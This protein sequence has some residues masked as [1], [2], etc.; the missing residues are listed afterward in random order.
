[1]IENLEY[2]VLLLPGFF[3]YITLIKFLGSDDERN[4][5]ETVFYSLMLSIIV[6][7]ILSILKQFE[8]VSFELFDWRFGFWIIVSYVIITVILL[9]FFKWIFPWIEKKTQL[10]DHVKS[11]TRD[12]LYDILDDKLNP[13]KT[14]ES[15][16]KKTPI[17]IQILTKDNTSYTGNLVFQGLT[18]DKKEAVYIKQPKI[19]NKDN[20]MNINPLDGVLFYTKDIKWIGIINQ[21]YKQSNKK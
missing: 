20:L 7:A 21:N 16:A 10:F 15:K 1:M 6:A 9:I 14:T 19:T 13:S 12:I 5:L 2:F 4:S 18:K 11:T 17:W 8:L 3:I